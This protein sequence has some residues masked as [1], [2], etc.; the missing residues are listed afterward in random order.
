MAEAQNNFVFLFPGQGAQFPGMGKDFYTASGK[1]RELF[2][3]ADQILGRSI[4]KLCFTGPEEELTKTANAQSA[5]FVTSLAALE[6]ARAL[7]PNFKPALACG[8]SL[9]EFTALVALEAM[10]FE[11]GLRL[12]Q[13]RG[14]LMEAACQ[15]HPGTM[16]SL[17]GLSL[18]L[19][20]EICKRTGAEL[21]NLNSP[22]QTVISGTVAQV[23]NACREAE[24][25]GAKRALPLKVGGA[26]HSSLM[27]D[28]EAGLRE[29]LKSIPI[30]EPKGKFIPNATATPEHNPERIRALLAE[31]L[32]HPVQWTK[33]MER[34]VSLG[35]K[36]L[37]EI[38]PGRVLKGLARKINSQ[39]NVRNI[40]K[41]ADLESLKSILEGS[42]HGV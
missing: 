41:Q 15:K 39:L 13:K 20:Q 22:D 21:A 30:R 18:E 7:Y 11:E 38:G 17:M 16:A 27:K 14:E 1:A 34:V 28:A 9:G 3:R 2:D 31:Q 37:F 25:K 6:A 19:C 33:T 5:I 26:F 40:E 4:S 24:A 42:L 36:Q 12:V 8:L 10:T 32:T 29:A 23:Q 35:L